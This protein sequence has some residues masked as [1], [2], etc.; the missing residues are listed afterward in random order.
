MN[1]VLLNGIKKYFKTLEYT[2]NI[3]SKETIKLYILAFLKEY[4]DN[5]TEMDDRIYDIFNCLYRGSCTINR[6][7]E[8]ITIVDGNGFTY[9]FDFNLS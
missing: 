9:T 3:N 5:L 4:I 7:L 8:C 6:R 1:E 2:G